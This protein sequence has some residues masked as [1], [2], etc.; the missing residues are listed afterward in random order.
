MTVEA[1]GRGD[2]ARLDAGAGRWRRLASERRAHGWRGG[3][4]MGGAE[5]S[6]PVSR[7][8]G[9]A[10]T[11]RTVYRALPDRGP[12]RVR[13]IGITLALTFGLTTTLAQAQSWRPPSD[14][15]RCP[16]KWGAGDERGAGNHMGKES[17]LRAVKLIKT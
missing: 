3:V 5:S 12:M 11:Y 8:T 6:T 9:L 2:P 15:Q 10:P 1:V 17:V 16:S 14:G 4:L 13:T 7:E